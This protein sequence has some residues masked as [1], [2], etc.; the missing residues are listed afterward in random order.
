VRECGGSGLVGCWDWWWLGSRSGMECR[1]RGRL[2]RRGRSGWSLGDA[3]SG[4]RLRNC[5]CLALLKGPDAAV[6][7]IESGSEEGDFAS[8]ARQPGPEDGSQDEP[9][10]RQDDQEGEHGLEAR[11]TG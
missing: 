11:G 6:G 3:G 9:Y 7:L 1:D 4:R 2:R 8:Q 5:E 10:E